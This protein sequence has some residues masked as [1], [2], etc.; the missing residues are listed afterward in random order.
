LEQVDLQ[1]VL[2]D[3][4]P[5]EKILVLVLLLLLVVAVVAI[6]FLILNL[7]T[8]LVVARMGKTEVLVEELVFGIVLVQEVVLE[9]LIKVSHLVLLEAQAQTMVVL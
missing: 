4:G 3:F 7:H 5:P 9:Q 6:G 8:L 1:P 2:M